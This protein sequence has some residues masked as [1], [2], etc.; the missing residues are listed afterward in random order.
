MSLLTF[1][2]HQNMKLFNKLVAE[3]LK[4]MALSDSSVEEPE[5]EQ[6][7]NSFF[8]GN[9]NNEAMGKNGEKERSWTDNQFWEFIDALLDE[10]CAEL[11][12]KPSKVHKKM[13][14][15]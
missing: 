11:E 3:S 8:D 10:M 12:G 13:W 7:D 9:H 14:E 5:P 2:K 1:V 15:M 4:K 6:D